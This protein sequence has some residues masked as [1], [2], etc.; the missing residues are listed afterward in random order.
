[1]NSNF[2]VEINLNYDEFFCFLFFFGIYFPNAST[3]RKIRLKKDC[4]V[5]TKYQR[6]MLIVS[7]LIILWKMGFIEKKNTSHTKKIP[8]LSD[9]HSFCRHIYLEVVGYSARIYS[10][11]LFLIVS[12]STSRFSVLIRTL[13]SPRQTHNTI[14]TKTVRNS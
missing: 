5:R 9:I 8:I 7:D 4:R 13:Y 10:Y 14:N 3:K 1:M 6:Q 12:G 11:I 2:C